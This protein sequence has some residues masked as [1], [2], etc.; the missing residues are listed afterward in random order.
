MDRFRTGMTATETVIKIV[1]I[2]PAI[3]SLTFEGYQPS[4]H[5]IVQPTEADALLYHRYRDPNRRFSLEKK[6]ITTEKITGIIRSLDPAECLVV[7]SA[8][9]TGTGTMHIPMVDFK[10]GITEA[11]ERNIVQFARKA[12]QPGVILISGLSYHFYGTKLLAPAEWISFMGMCLL[13]TAYIDYEWVGHSLI[14][15]CNHLRLT[16]TALRPEIPRV[17]RI[18]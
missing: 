6:H 8:V 4:K 11:N 12:G 18:T 17:V 2:N 3:R 13:L 7:A 15:G 9:I 16:N 5:A 10:C 14:D 1:E